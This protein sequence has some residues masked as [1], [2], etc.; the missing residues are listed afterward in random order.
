M[1]KLLIGLVSISLLGCTAEQANTIVNTLASVSP[2]PIVSATV[3]TVQSTIPSPSAALIPSVNP[4]SLPSVASITPAPTSSASVSITSV[5]NICKPIYGFDFAD[6]L[7]PLD[8]SNFLRKAKI[9]GKEGFYNLKFLEGKTLNYFSEIDDSI[10]MEA[11]KIWKW[12]TRFKLK[13]VTEQKNALLI[14]KYT[15]LNDSSGVFTASERWGSSYTTLIK[16]TN[17]EKDKEALVIA[18]QYISIYK[19]ISDS[20]KKLVLSHEMGHLE[21]LGHSDTSGDLMSPL[22]ETSAFL[23]QKDLTTFEMLQT[24]KCDWNIY[25][26]EEYQKLIQAK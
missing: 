12:D 25:T 4:T 21:G 18:Y 22:A 15:N 26:D 11:F 8:G 9:D 2:S 14:V 13:K 24:K 7:P 5:P 17:K 1:K 16:C 6:I 20:D 19:Q 10:L 23:R 3:S